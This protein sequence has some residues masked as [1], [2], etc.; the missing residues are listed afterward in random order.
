VGDALAAVLAQPVFVELRAGRTTNIPTDR[1]LG[2][3]VT[4]RDWPKLLQRVPART[5]RSSGCS[6]T[7][8]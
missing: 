2:G 5:R 1:L 3:D 8:R 7:R 6:M 4:D